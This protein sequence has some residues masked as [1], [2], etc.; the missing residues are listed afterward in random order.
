MS[1]HLL[2]IILVVTGIAALAVTLTKGPNLG[3]SRRTGLYAGAVLLI[4]G[5][6]LFVLR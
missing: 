4:I 5:V 1:L 3:L 6:V 2:G